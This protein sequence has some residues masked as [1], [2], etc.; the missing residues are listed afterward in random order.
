MRASCMIITT[1]S[2]LSH[3][4]IPVRLGGADE[5]GEH[6]SDATGLHHCA[7]GYRHHGARCAAGSIASFVPNAAAVPP[8]LSRLVT[9]YSN[10]QLLNALIA[11]SD[12]T[13]SK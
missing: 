3:S 6:T 2:P 13:S 1:Y 4:K 11:R 10:A 8:I 7:E 12:S 5:E 9:I